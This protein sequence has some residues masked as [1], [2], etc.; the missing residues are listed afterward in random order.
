LLLILCLIE[1]NVC[2]YGVV[3]GSLDLVP[4]ITYAVYSENNLGIAE[5]VVNA[6]AAFGIIL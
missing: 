3:I 2:K 6:L 1:L 4:V 5:N